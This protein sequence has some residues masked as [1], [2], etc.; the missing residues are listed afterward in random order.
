MKVHCVY[1]PPISQNYKNDIF[2]VNLAWL[3]KLW[4]PL[5]EVRIV[6]NVQN[7]HRCTR[8]EDS[9]YT[10]ACCLHPILYVYAH[11]IQRTPA[12]VRL[13]FIFP[14]GLRGLHHW[15]ADLRR[16]RF[17]SG[18]VHFSTVIHEIQYSQIFRQ[19]PV[20][21]EINRKKR[22]KCRKSTCS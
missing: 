3:L 22:D 19:I 6:Q 1:Q 2:I 12:C 7:V 10:V 20:I 17:S 16:S 9:S 13:S 11:S 14:P 21:M 4:L 8:F 15:V 5:S 18:F